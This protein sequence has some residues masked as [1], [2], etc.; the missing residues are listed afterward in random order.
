MRLLPL[1]QK[2]KLGVAKV[3]IAVAWVGFSALVESFASACPVAAKQ[4]T[5]ARVEGSGMLPLFLRL[6]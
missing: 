2:I 1:G 6:N 4:P 5:A 3:A